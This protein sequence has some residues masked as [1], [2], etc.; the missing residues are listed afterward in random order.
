MLLAAAAA[1][2]ST[3][4]AA[5]VV[6]D[7]HA[8][9][10]IKKITGTGDAAPGLAWSV[11]AA[12]TFGKPF[13]EF[14]DPRFG[15]EYGSWTPGFLDAGPVLVA[16]I[17]V[18]EGEYSL[19]EAVM[20]GVDARDGSVR[21]Q[22]PARGLGGCGT[23]PVGGEVVC[24]RGYGDSE[25]VAFDTAT[26]ASR[27]TPSDLRIF[28]IA[29][30]AD[31]VFVAEGNP[32]DNDVRVRAG[33]V[34][35]PSAAWSRAFDVGDS[36]ESFF[37][38]DVL[39]TTHGVGLIQLGG[40]VVAFDPAT[41][42]QRWR[43]HLRDCVRDATPSVGGVVVRVDADCSTSVVTA[44]EVRGADG[45]V[46]AHSTSEAAHS[47]YIDA[48]AD[49]AVPVLLGNTA[50]DRATG[51]ALWTSP[52]LVST[53][54]PGDGNLPS[55]HGTA[56]AVAGEVAVL[57]DSATETESGLDLRTGQHLW[58]RTA[59]SHHTPAAFNG[60]GTLLHTGSDGLVAV[61]VRTGAQLWQ[62]PF[63]AIDTDRDAF[64][65]HGA[66]AATAHGWAYA[67]TRRLI[68]LAPLP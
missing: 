65:S 31:W 11:D 7:R 18:A 45:A 52:D 44:Q 24:W 32:E 30:T 54:R 4:A 58:R 16:L 19:G 21:W 6:V 47:L 36:W 59:L 40:E 57:R 53:P 66:A 61:D 2:V 60:R 50:H 17:A 23:V 35:D 27:T 8:P 26:G 1:A 15:S 41:G 37:P 42:G 56:V 12:A 29:T 25:L 64:A 33:T 39:D 5:V 62:V 14:H 67:S 3:V 38:S 68:G 49:A 51:A 55:A 9:T 48:P 13:A 34:T 22:S 43:T 63:A 46:L 20:V 28:A 10:S